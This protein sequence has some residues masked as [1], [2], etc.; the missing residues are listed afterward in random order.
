VDE[1]ILAEGVVHLVA[2]ILVVVVVILVVAG[3]QE[4]GNGIQ[5]L[6]KG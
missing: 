2:V 3:H 6:F 4:T 5:T 1:E